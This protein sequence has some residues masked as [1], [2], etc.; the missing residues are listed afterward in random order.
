MTMALLA[1]SA[2]VAIV[3]AAPD[4][5]DLTELGAALLVVAFLLVVVVIVAGVVSELSR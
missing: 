5:D 3:M 4:V 1:G 2:F